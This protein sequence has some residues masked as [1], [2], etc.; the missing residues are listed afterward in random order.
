MSD[1]GRNDDVF[2]S[3]NFRQNHKIPTAECYWLSMKLHQPIKSVP[4]LKL[5][6][7]LNKNV[8]AYPINS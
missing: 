3:L 1:D 4:D 2:Y 8:N 6:T 7:Q 5:Y